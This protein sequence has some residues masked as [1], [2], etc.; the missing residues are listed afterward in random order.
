MLD[1]YLVA[2]VGRQEEDDIF[3]VNQAAFTVCHFALIERLVAAVD[4]FRPGQ[5]GIL[6][7]KTDSF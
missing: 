7:L 6:R 2:E 5:H 4:V 3:A 1:Y